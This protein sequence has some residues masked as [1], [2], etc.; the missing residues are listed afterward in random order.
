MT[1]SDREYD[2]F[3][4]HYE[5]FVA[6]Y[7]R[8]RVHADLIADL[9]AEV[10]GVAWRK[11]RTVPDDALPWLYRTAYNVIGNHYRAAG[12]QRALT[13]KL[14]SVP[15]EPASDPAVIST[16]RADFTQAFND[17]SASDQ[18][19]LLLVAWEGLSTQ[20]VAAA[21]NISA[22]TAAVRVHRARQRLEQG[23][24]SDAELST[25]GEHA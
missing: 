1:R 14:Q 22:G 4:A 11:R 9:V 8:R 7:V 17:L 21:T 16:A 6:A 23:L 5:P 25:R 20:E 3:H 19:L 15:V 10:F 12:R 18:E 24:T 13:E 2:R